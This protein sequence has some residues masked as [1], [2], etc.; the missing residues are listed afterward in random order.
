MKGFEGATTLHIYK[1]ILTL[2]TMVSFNHEQRCAL[3]LRLTYPRKK[4]LS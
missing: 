1:L 2:K 3:I 4:F